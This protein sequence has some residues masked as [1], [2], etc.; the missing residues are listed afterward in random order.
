MNEYLLLNY[1]DEMIYKESLNSNALSHFKL[2]VCHV[3][4]IIIKTAPSHLYVAY[5]IIALERKNTVA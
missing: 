2:C 3:V 1:S 5:K 4:M